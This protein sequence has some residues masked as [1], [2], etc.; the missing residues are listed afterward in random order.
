ML[1]E[2]SQLDFHTDK[3]MSFHSFTNQEIDIMLPFPCSI[4]F[5]AF[6]L[7]E[8]SISFKFQVFECH[9]QSSGLAQIEM[10]F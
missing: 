3:Q 9:Q 5:A 10:F 1:V 2:Q 7:L 6:I 8:F 4:G